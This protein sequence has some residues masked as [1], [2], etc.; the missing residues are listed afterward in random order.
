MFVVCSLCLVKE[1]D[2]RNN[3]RI[4]YKSR[5]YGW[6]GWLRRGVIYASGNYLPVPLCLC[7]SHV[8]VLQS[9]IG[10]CCRGA[11]GGLRWGKAGPLRFACSD[12]TGPDGDNGMS[13]CQLLGWLGG[14]CYL[15]I[16]FHG[17]LSMHRSVAAFY[18]WSCDGRP[19]PP[20]HKINEHK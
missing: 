7:A 2:E 4:S 18:S 1:I 19:F 5:F 20:S 9:D 10:G 3:L 12:C 14:V 15:L 16:V 13:S 8:C 11:G 17:E 6:A